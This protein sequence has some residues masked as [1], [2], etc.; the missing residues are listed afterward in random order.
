MC[1][2]FFMKAST[3]QFWR[4][5][6]GQGLNKKH[7]FHVVFTS[8]FPLPTGKQQNPKG[9]LLRRRLVV[10]HSAVEIRNNI[11]NGH[12][13]FFCIKARPNLC[14]KIENRLG[15]CR[16]LIKPPGALNNKLVFLLFEETISLWL[17][18]L[19]VKHNTLGGFCFRRDH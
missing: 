16:T 4:A 3:T 13:L 11:T 8:G 15:W 14:P 9:R 12:V 10:F 6:V 2:C 19:S 17:N 5:K 18:A 1:V 7:N